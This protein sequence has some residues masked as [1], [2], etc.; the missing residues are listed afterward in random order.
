M[1]TQV[2]KIIK[3]IQSLNN[4]NIRYPNLLINQS[5]KQPLSDE[6]ARSIAEGVG[7]KFID[8]REDVLPF[9]NTI[10]LG[11]YT[12]SEFQ[13]LLNNSTK[14]NSGIMLWNGDALISTWDERDRKAFFKEFLLNG[15]N[16]GPSTV[17]VSWLGSSF[18]LE[19]IHNNEIKIIYMDR[20]DSMEG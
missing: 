1:N 20:I 10:T 9:D 14:T 7:L 6:A 11:A 4:N 16:Y 3:V 2:S 18:D 17:L 19:E 5:I 13:E 12:R 15:L 8:F